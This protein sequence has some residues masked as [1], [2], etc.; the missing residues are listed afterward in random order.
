MYDEFNVVKMPLLA[1]E[2]V[3]IAYILC[4]ISVGGKGGVG[5]PQY[6]NLITE[7]TTVLY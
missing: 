3:A 5:K 4:W 6:L 7:G 2:V 1:A